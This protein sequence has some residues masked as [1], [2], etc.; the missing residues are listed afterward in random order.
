M[1]AA[2][3]ATIPSRAQGPLFAGGDP[4]EIAGGAVEFI[5]AQGRAFAAAK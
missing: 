1:N 2:S 3:T 4:G 5:D